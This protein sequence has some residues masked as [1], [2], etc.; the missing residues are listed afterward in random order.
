RGSGDATA[1]QKRAAGTPLASKAASKHAPSLHGNHGSWQIDA[2]RPPPDTAPY[3]TAPRMLLPWSWK[4][5]LDR[6]CK[7]RCVVRCCISDRQFIIRP[8]G[9]N[10][11]HHQNRRDNARQGKDQRAGRTRETDDHDTRQDR[12]TLCQGLLPG[13]SWFR[14]YGHVHGKSTALA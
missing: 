11:E 5:L 8:K 3:R 14:R 4:A 6:R 9:P 2:A 7:L 12:Q 1:R 10:L 13:P